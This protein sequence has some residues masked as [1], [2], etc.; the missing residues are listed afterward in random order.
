MESHV[1]TYNQH[2][3]F[4]ELVSRRASAELAG[5]EAAM[6]MPGPMPTYSSDKNIQALYERGFMDG[7]AK[8]EIQ[9]VTA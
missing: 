3:K 1:I 8:L 4:L 5:Y 2:L 6:H 7:K 9:Q